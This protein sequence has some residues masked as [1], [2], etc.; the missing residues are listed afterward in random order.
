M[1]NVINDHGHL[2]GVFTDN[3]LRRTFNNNYN[4]YWTPIK[5]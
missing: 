5:K 4:I 3:D 1:T 2:V